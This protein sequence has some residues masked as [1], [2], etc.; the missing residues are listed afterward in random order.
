MLYTNLTTDL[1]AEPLKQLSGFDFVNHRKDIQ[2]EVEALDKKYNDLLDTEEDLKKVD[3]AA[4]AVD[5]KMEKYFESLPLEVKM[6]FKIFGGGLAKD[7]QLITVSPGADAFY[8]VEF[9]SDIN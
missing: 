6:F 1:Y 4:A 7:F 9:F 2:L 5:K 8:K 3:K